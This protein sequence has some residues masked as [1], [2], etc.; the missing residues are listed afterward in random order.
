M[1]D[2]R[3]WYTPKYFI[4]EVSNN[5]VTGKPE[6]TYKPNGNKYWEDREKGNW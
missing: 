3:M 4:K 2:E 5:P 1:Y 6:Y